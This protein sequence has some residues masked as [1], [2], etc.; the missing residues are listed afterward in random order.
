MR[1]PFATGLTGGE[2]IDVVARASGELIKSPGVS[3]VG[4]GIDGATGVM[5]V[6]AAVLQVVS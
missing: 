3:R 5:Q 6:G 4:E 2:G 1:G